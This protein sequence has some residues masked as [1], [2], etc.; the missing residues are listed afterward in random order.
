MISMDKTKFDSVYIIISNIELR[1]N[2]ILN[3]KYYA[4]YILYENGFANIAAKTKR[5]IYINI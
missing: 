5:Y 3:F 4:Y 2:I 1:V